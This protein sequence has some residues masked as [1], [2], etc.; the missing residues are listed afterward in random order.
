MVNERLRD[1]GAAKEDKPD[2]EELRERA[3]R[4]EHAVHTITLEAERRF[5]DLEQR[6]MI[7][8]RQEVANRVA[9]QMA[10]PN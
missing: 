10:L 5:A 8:L 3:E 4:R 9:A 2:P 1:L 7:D 6:P